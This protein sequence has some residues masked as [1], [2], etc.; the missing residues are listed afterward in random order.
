MPFKDPEKRRA[1]Q[2][3]ASKRHY[4]KNKQAYIERSAKQKSEQR[5]KW[6]EFKRTLSCIWCGYNKNP[7]CLDHHHVIRENHRKVHRLIAN[8][9]IGAAFE[10]IKKCVVLCANCHR[11]AHWLERNGSPEEVYEMQKYFESFLVQ[12]GLKT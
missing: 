4:E 6:E 11:Y 12:E 1:Y 8:G 3:L 7:E 5:L 9:S 10:E 2:R